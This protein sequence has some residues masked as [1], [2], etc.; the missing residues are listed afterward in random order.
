MF[1][2]ESRGGMLVIAV[3]LARVTGIRRLL[4]GFMLAA[5]AVTC[6]A[7]AG[8][9]ELPASPFDQPMIFAIVRSSAANCEPNCPEW[10]Y[11]EGQIRQETPA[12]F[13]KI[14]KRAGGRRLPLILLSPG[15]NVDA[16]MEMGRIVRDRRMPVEVGF[17]RFAT[18][19]PRD[20]GCAGDGVAKGEFRGLAIAEGAF[21]WS[22]CPLVLA[23]GAERYSSLLSSTGVHQV[24][25][26]YQRE[27]VYFRERYRIVNGEKKVVSRKI[28]SREAAGTTKTTKLPR[29]TRSLLNA[30]FKEMG[31]GR[32]LIAIMQSTPSNKIRR[33][34]PEELLDLRLVTAITPDVYLG[35][36][37]ICMGEKPPA[38][39][40]LRPEYGVAE[41]TP[42][43]MPV[44]D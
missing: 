38:H 15:G 34:K 29:K 44:A 17:T 36:P 33:L 40:I 21:C 4:A 35:D 11:A 32:D 5:L 42:P 22:A 31:V 39:C 41:A 7:G 37:G 16:A 12:A 1:R 25:T 23:A 28:I 18:C 26:V 19:R 9:G 8:A 43:A 6:G 13:R 30:Y 14:L 24:T 20:K 27:K 10:I 3:R 2:L